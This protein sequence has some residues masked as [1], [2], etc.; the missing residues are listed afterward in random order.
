[1]NEMSVLQKLDSWF[2]RGDIDDTARQRGLK[3]QVRNGVG[4]QLMESLAVGAFLTAYA[5]Q[6]G[7]SNLV[8]GLLA[9]IPALMNLVQ[10]P[11]VFLVDKVQNRRAIS[12]FSSCL[13]RPALLIA[14]SAAFMS[15]P[16]L[17]IKLLIA[18]YVVRYA[19]GA[20]NTC[21]W[22]SWMRDLIPAQTRGRFNAKRLAWMT[23]F[24][25]LATLGGGLFMDAWPDFTELPKSYGFAFLIFVAFLC[26]T[27]SMLTLFKI[28]ESPMKITPETKVTAASLLLPLKDK[29]YRSLI[30]FLFIWNFA[31][32]LATPFFTV[33]MLTRLDISLTL[34]MI[35]TMLSSLANIAVL[36]A[37]GQIADRFSYKTVLGFSAPL[38]L[39]CIFAWTFTSVQGP[40]KFTLILLFAIHILTG[41]ATG[42]VTL[43]TSNINM[44][45]AKEHQAS[46]YIAVAAVA[47]SLAAGLS[48]IIGGA[49]ADV[50]A[51]YEVKVMID[52]TSPTKSISKTALDLTHWDFY[53]IIAAVLGMLS[54]H[55]LAILQ[56]D[57]DT[58]DARVGREILMSLR[59]GL[60]DM[61]SIGGSRDALDFLA[62]GGR[63]R[64]RKSRAKPEVK[65][66]VKEKPQR[67]LAIKPEK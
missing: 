27:A 26:G 19:A 62:M 55:F 21:A 67:K 64:Q 33:H 17:G 24:G 38:F 47:A 5:L 60:S 28:P 42:G 51:N 6:L 9:A 10:L 61:S 12:F 4:V 41:V 22:N 57:G 49:F 50:L 58:K 1:M 56:E 18:G 15:S 13:S 48:P 36:T 35:L 40:H 39:M 14:A 46:S 59:N 43:S 29:N 8:I 3:W 30:T 7:A 63:L 23:A 34:V 66:P 20:V 32:G 31:V 52:W 45:L 25:M 16:D 2:P 44:K 54:L 37:W 53:F 65:K 11:T